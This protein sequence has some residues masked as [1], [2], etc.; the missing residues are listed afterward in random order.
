MKMS[1]IILSAAAAS[2]LSTAV[3]AAPRSAVDTVLN[4]TKTSLMISER[5]TSAFGNGRAAGYTGSLA[6]QTS[7]TSGN[8]D[9]STMRWRQYG[10]L[11]RHE[12]STIQFSYQR[13]ENEGTVDE[14]S[15]LHEAQYTLFCDVVLRF[16]QIAGQHEC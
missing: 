2:P 10:L 11:R 1:K 13:S 7:A 15:L 16:R 9:T 3:F 5:D 4:P 14:N 8:S 6:L 12:R